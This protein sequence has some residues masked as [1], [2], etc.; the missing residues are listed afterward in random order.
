MVC[1]FIRPTVK[2]LLLELLFLCGVR[3]TIPEGHSTTKHLKTGAN[4]VN[5]DQL[6]ALVC[7]QSNALPVFASLTFSSSL[8]ICK[9]SSIFLSIPL[10][11]FG[12][13]HYI[14]SCDAFQFG[15]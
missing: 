8:S 1:H 7:L 9:H 10:Q 13:A 6:C 3:M 15:L 2:F 4:L 5:V 14:F 12:K 11:V